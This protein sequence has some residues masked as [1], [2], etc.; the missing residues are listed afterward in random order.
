MRRLIASAILIC[1]VV[2]GCAPTLVGDVSV[3]VYVNGGLAKLDPPA[4][5]R[6]GKTYVGLRGVAKALMGSTKW[7]ERSKTA[8]VTVGHKRT[9]VPQ[10]RGITV[11]GVLFLPLRAIG[12]AVGCTV[13][14]DCGR[15]AISITSEPSCPI[16]GG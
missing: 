10:S 1:A 2:L 15:R 9:N 14:W 8:M 4:M 16:G 13:E 7:I 3:R 11:N 6:G 12:E 5:M